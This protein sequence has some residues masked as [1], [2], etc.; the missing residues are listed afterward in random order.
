MPHDRLYLAFKRVD[1][2]VIEVDMEVEE[3]GWRDGLGRLGTGKFIRIV[4]NR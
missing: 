2:L 4:E 1:E 3:M